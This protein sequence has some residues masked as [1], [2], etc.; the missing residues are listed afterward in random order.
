VKYKVNEDFDLSVGKPD[1]ITVKAGS[2]F[3]PAET[4]VP[5]HTVA[6]LEKSGAI[7]LIRPPKPKKK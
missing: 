2:T 5:Q 3:I 4:N 7:E 6:A 1:P